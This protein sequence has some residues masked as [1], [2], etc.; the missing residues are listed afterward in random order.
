MRVLH[1]NDKTPI[2]STK[3]YLSTVSRNLVLE[4]LSRQSREITMEINDALR[5]LPEKKRR[6]ILLRKFYGLSHNE[7]AKKKPLGCRCAGW[8]SLCCRNQ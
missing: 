2:C 4:K 8:C 3:G 7:I 1:A 6:A 5:A